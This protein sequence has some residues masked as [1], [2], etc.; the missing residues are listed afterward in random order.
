MS[1]SRDYSQ[2]ISFIFTHL[3]A[4][5][6]SPSNSED[7]AQ[8]IQVQELTRGVEF[9]KVL[10]AEKAPSEQPQKSEL[11]SYSPLELLSRGREA[12][13]VVLEE[14]LKNTFK[15]M[16]DVQARLKFML[17]ELKELTQS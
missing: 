12:S 17:A 3:K 2:N 1:A 4:S 14:S 11:K 5:A 8:F 7:Q 6:A 13:E 9:G 10:K 16:D 15:Q